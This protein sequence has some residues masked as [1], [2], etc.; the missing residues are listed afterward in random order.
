MGEVDDGRDA[1]F[2]CA[3]KGV[4]REDAR[5]HV[6]VTGDAALGNH[7]LRRSRLRDEVDLA[8]EAEAA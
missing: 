4:A 3:A 2:D 1:P 6:R 8:S 7:V 5:E